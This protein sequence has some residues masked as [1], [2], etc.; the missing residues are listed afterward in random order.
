M[1]AG[2]GTSLHRQSSPRA[3]A[4]GRPAG[5]AQRLRLQRR[6]AE[7]EAACRPFGPT[8][9]TGPIAVEHVPIPPAAPTARLDPLGSRRAPAA[10]ELPP[11]VGR[12]ARGS[13][14]DDR[15]ARGAGS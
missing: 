1:G 3:P 15:G 6:P 11:G 12:R 5:S 7:A 13:R 2:A 14:A 4:T 10:E 8:D 9:A